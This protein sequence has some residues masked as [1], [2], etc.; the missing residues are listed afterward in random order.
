MFAKFDWIRDPANPILA[1]EADRPFECY[2]CM[3]PFVVRVGE[4]YRLYYSG[5]DVDK[6]QRICLATASIHKPTEFKRHGV[7]LD[8]GETDE[9]DSNW[10]FLPQVYRI[11]DKW[12]LYYSAN[13]RSKRVPRPP[14]G[15]GLATSDDGINFKRHPAGPIIFGNH[16]GLPSDKVVVAGGSML[17]ETRPD[18]SASYRMYYTPVIPKPKGSDQ[19]DHHKHCA[20]C[21]STDGVEW[22]DHRLL[23]SPRPDVAKED[24]AVAVPVV[25]RDGE[26]YRMLYSGIGTRWGAYSISEA[27]STDGYV[28]ERGEGEE[29]LSLAPGERE[30]EAKMVEYPSVIEGPGQI[31]LFYCGNKYGCTGIGT[32]TAKR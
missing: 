26:L 21:H 22:T 30:W 28:W 23:L 8:L 9:F 18:G 27:Y 16:V 20:V 7:I 32:A 2:R 24:C 5:G 17:M 19:I 29:N 11:G 15:I 4:E 31:R 13:S 3:N 12:H 1:P 6:R 10:L 25:W 14:S